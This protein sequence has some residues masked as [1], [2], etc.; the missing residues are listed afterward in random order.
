LRF[1]KGSGWV[2]L[3]LLLN[4]CTPKQAILDRWDEIDVW[5]ERLRKW[6]GPWDSKTSYVANMARWHGVWQSGT[7]ADPSYATL[8]RWLNNEIAVHLA[9]FVTSPQLDHPLEAPPAIE[10]L[11][12]QPSWCVPPDHWASSVFNAIRI[13]EDFGLSRA[14]IRDYCLRAVG[15]L[16]EAWIEVSQQTGPHTFDGWWHN[17]LHHVQ[18]QARRDHP[19]RGDQPLDRD[20]IIDKLKQ[21]RRQRPPQYLPQ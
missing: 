6:Q 21:W 7:K 2:V 20:R 3:S 15:A 11:L 5:R 14:A 12:A 18:S 19:I 16:T 10:R 9:M 1:E 17:L 8:A 4:E 13:M